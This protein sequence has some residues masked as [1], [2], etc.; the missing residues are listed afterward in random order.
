MQ[1]N[2]EYPQNK[3]VAYAGSRH[4]NYNSYNPSMKQVNYPSSFSISKMEFEITQIII[5]SVIYKF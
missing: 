1:T 5:Q 3:L 2:K 4:K